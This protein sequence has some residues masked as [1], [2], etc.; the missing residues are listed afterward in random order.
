MGTRA[1]SAL[2]AQERW[3]A[4]AATLGYV[5]APVAARLAPL[6]DAGAL[7][8]HGP[9]M[10]RAGPEGEAGDPAPT[11]R[12]CLVAAETVVAAATPATRGLPAA[13]RRRWVL[14]EVEAAAEAGAERREWGGAAAFERVLDQAVA[15]S[16][17][18]AK[19]EEGDSAVLVL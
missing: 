7:R 12:A 6:L 19:E 8:V 11:L 18:L 5:P 13:A 16:P 14:E 4:A 3:S 17:L 15:C 10:L 1:S 2:C 9:C